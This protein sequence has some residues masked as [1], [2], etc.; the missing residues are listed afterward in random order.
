MGTFWETN[1]QTNK[2]ASEQ[3]SKHTNKQA[4]KQ[5]SKH[6]SKQANSPTKEQTNKQANKQASKQTSKEARKQTLIVYIAPLRALFGTGLSLQVEPR[7]ANMA[8]RWAKIA[9]R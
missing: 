4:D 3:T 9:P 7:R 2:Q 6:T 8:P 5:T 1:K